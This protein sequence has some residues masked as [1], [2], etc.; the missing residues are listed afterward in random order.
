MTDFALE[1]LGAPFPRLQAFVLGFQPI[2]LAEHRGVVASPA[3]TVAKLG[4]GRRG[5]AE[6]RRSEIGE[7]VARLEDDAMIDATENQK[8]NAKK[9]EAENEQLAT[10]PRRRGSAPTEIVSHSTHQKSLKAKR[11]R[12]RSASPLRSRDKHAMPF[13]CLFSIMA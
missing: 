4:H 5:G 7:T 13:L 12:W 1:L 8:N 11:Y 2:E 10:I 3:N 9:I 6:E